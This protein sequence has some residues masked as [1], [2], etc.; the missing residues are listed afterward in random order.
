[1]KNDFVSAKLVLRFMLRNDFRK[2][3][4]LKKVCLV[5]VGWLVSL[6]VVGVGAALIR[7]GSS[8]Y[9]KQTNALFFIFTTFFPPFFPLCVTKYQK[10]RVF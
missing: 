6:L 1:M 9:S 2:T 5:V 10:K 3:F 7:G 4:F 8:R